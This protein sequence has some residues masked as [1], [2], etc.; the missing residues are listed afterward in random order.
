MKRSAS[1]MCLMS[2]SEQSHPRLRPKAHYKKFLP[3]CK[4]CLTPIKKK[5]Q[6][7]MMIIFFFLLNGCTIYIYI[8][9]YNFFFMSNARNVTNFITENLQT[10]MSLITKK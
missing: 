2:L 9:I 6:N 1:F 3:L 8:Y 5:V 7:F 10:Y 4:K